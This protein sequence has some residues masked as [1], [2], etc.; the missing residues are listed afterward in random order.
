MMMAGHPQLLGKAC[1][2]TNL[3]FRGTSLTGWLPLAYVLL[4]A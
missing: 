2:R 4:L 3:N 1:E